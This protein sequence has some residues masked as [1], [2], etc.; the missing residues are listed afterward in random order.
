[1]R[2]GRER[3]RRP[4]RLQ[5]RCSSCASNYATFLES[6]RG[7]L[8]E[9]RLGYALDHLLAVRGVEELRDLFERYPE[10]RTDQAL[11]RINEWAAGATEGE[12]ITSRTHN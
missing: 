7:S 4:A 2:R 8:P 11:S 9:R 12:E 3:G 5:G 1:M 10:L 6:V